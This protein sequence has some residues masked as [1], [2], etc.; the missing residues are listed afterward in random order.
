MNILTPIRYKNSFFT[1]SYGG[2]SF[3]YDLAGEKI[4]P[5]SSWNN[6][7]QAY[8]SSPVVLGD[9]AYMHLRNQRLICLNL[10][11]GET[12]WT[13]QPF[14]KYWSMITDG[15]RILGLDQKGVLYLIDGTPESLEIL[16]QKKVSDTETWAHVA[17]NNGNIYIR[18]LNKLM[19]YSMNQTSDSTETAVSAAAKLK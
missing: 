7:I 4:K 18:S 19:C 9:H 1:S 8:M 17:I 6:T 16:S 12:A 3:L 14:G 5:E 11:N 2:G 13:S 15:E 10:K